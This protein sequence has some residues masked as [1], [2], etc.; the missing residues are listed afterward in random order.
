MQVSLLRTGSPWDKAGI[1]KMIS[2]SYLAQNVLQGR[3][4]VQDFPKDSSSHTVCSN[5]RGNIKAD[6]VRMGNA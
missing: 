5:H 2:G 3:E 1:L 6:L 4:L